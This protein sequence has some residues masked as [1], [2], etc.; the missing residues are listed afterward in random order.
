MHQ[1][2]E[3]LEKELEQVKAERNKYHAELTDLKLAQLSKDIADHEARI[4]PLE[5][6]QV[7]AN[8]IYTL[9]AGNS[10]LSIIALVKIFSST[11]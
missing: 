4:R 5:A 3:D 9:F 2:P 7:K 10:L 1:S 6:G 8:T 11:Q